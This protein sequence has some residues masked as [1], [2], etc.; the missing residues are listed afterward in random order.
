MTFAKTAMI[1]LS[2]LVAGTG[3]AFA[4]YDAWIAG[5]MG[6]YS[7]TSMSAME[8]KEMA[9]A[10]C[11]EAEGVECSGAFA[12]TAGSAVVSASCAMGDMS[13]Y[14]VGQSEMAVEKM[15]EASDFT[16]EDCS[17]M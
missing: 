10:K 14:V 4:D 6:V 8:A 3:A 15:I 7:A 16:A 5:G 17:M 2:F 1:T 13:G 11:S 9:T 12:L